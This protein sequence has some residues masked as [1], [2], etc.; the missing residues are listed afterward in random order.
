MSK[1]NFSEEK[2]REYSFEKGVDAAFERIKELYNTLDRDI[3][4]EINGSNVNV[5]KSELLRQ[6]SGRLYEVGILSTNLERTDKELFAEVKKF[7]GAEDKKVY[8]VSDTIRKLFDSTESYRKALRDNDLLT[9]DLY[10]GIYSPD[11]PFEGATGP[12]A[13]MII[14]NE[15]ATE[16]P[17]PF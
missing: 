17:K 8:I 6:L 10:I 15:H 4:V 11:R 13:D 3:I 7:E 12:V 14:K 16:K 1:E 9:A 5:G 2:P